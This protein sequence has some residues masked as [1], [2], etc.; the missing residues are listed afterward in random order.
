MQADLKLRLHVR[1]LA[2]EETR[3]PVV[4]DDRAPLTFVAAGRTETAYRVVERT[5]E[6]GYYV[7]AVVFPVVAMN[8][9]GVGFTVTR[10]H[11]TD[12]INGVV[13]T[14]NRILGEELAAEGET[15]EE[16]R[17]T[18]RPRES[19]TAATRAKLAVPHA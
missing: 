5:L 7:K 15:L 17:R 1:N 10:H 13:A 6:D 9:A 3:L 16:V 14:I 8:R 18:F 11:T 12:D 2:I 4:S 19:G